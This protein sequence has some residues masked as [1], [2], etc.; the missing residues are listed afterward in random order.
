MRFDVAPR[1]VETLPVFHANGWGSPYPPA[2][3]GA[4]QVVLRKVGGA[5][6][7]RRVDAHGVT[8][9]CGA[10]AVWNAVLDAAAPGTGRS[11]A[12]PRADRVRRRPTADAHDP[13]HRRG[14]GLGVHPDLR[15][16]RDLADVTFNRTRPADTALPAPPGN[17]HAGW[18]GPE[19][20][21]PR[22]LPGRTRPRRELV[23]DARSGG[24]RSSG[25]ALPV[26]TSR[27]LEQVLPLLLPRPRRRRRRGPGTAQ[28]NHHGA[29]H[30]QHNGDDEPD[31][32][33]TP[34]HG[35]DRRAVCSAVQ[36]ALPVS[37]R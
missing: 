20:H 36:T 5:E 4:T 31:H 3:L 30:D 22:A 6:I 24:A 18:E 21:A 29:R 26:R 15:A 34:P 17:A 13:A 12:G 9:M 23:G 11:P 35:D 32:A 37:R 19:V 28:S 1:M 8:V 14:T 10:P 2:G 16:E 7:L 27:R 33:T 25:S